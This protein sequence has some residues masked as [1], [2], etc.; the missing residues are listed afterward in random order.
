MLEML[1]NKDDFMFLEV[2]GEKIRGI[3]KHRHDI[4]QNLG[5]DFFDDRNKS[6]FMGRESILDATIVGVE[7]GD[8]T[9]EEVEDICVVRGTRSGQRTERQIR[10]TSASISTAIAIM[11]STARATGLLFLLRELLSLLLVLD[12]LC[13]D[14]EIIFLDLDRLVLELDLDRLVLELDLVLLGLNGCLQQG[15]GKNIPLQIKIPKNR[16]M[17]YTQ[18][19]IAGLLSWLRVQSFKGAVDQIL[20]CIR[21]PNRKF[22][23]GEIRRNI[24]DYA[25]K[26]SKTLSYLQFNLNSHTSNKSSQPLPLDAISKPSFVDNVQEVAN[27]STHEINLKKNENTNTT[28]CFNKV[29]PCKLKESFHKET[30]VKRRLLGGIQKKA[31]C[32]GPLLGLRT[33]AMVY[34]DHGTS[35]QQEFPPRTRFRDKNDLDKRGNPYAAE[36]EMQC[37]KYLKSVHHMPINSVKQ[38]ALNRHTFDIFGPTEFDQ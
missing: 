24:E 34:L 36:N 22:V 6:F 10:A 1:S 38:S 28:E 37:A 26:S 18:R 30:Q 8:D 21:T 25:C 20:A 5:F 31:G 19:H 7:R 35:G 15:A 33:D 16:G 27:L 3:K 11:S 23:E 4:Y 17:S 9:C 13:L 32:H 12:L 2:G 14:L 29:L